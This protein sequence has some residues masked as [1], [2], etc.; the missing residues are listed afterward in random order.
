[1]MFNWVCIF[2]LTQGFK[3]KI[4][5][6]WQDFEVRE[7]GLDSKVADIDIDEGP[8]YVISSV[9]ALQTVG[10][11]VTKEPLASP[12]NNAK[13]SPYMRENKFWLKRDSGAKRV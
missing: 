4:K 3:G 10:E 13:L 11:P 9:F 8:K 1:M 7:V 6:H 2:D 12:S 5:K